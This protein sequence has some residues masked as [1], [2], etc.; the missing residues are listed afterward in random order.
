MDGVAVKQI[1]RPSSKN[2]YEN[3]SSIF[4]IVIFI[5][6]IFLIPILGIVWN[7]RIKKIRLFL[8]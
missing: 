4:V 7:K 1:I 3:Y 6:Q 5:I 2:F 8:K